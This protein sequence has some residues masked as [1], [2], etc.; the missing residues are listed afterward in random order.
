RDHVGWR[1]HRRDDQR[2]DNEVAALADELVRGDDADA[3]EQ[4]QDHGKLERDAECEDQLH[5]QREVVIHLGQ[6][7]DDRAALAAGLLHAEREPR[8]HRPKHAVHHQRAEQEEER[9]RDQVGPEGVALVSVQPWRDEHVELRRHHRKREEG[10]A[11]HRDLQLHHE[12]L[13]K[14]GVDELAIVE[15]CD[16]TVRKGEDIED[17]LGEEEADHERDHERDCC[18]DQA[19]AQLDQVL[20]QR[21][22]G[23]LDVL[24][25][26]AAR[27]PPA[28]GAAAAGSLVATAGSAAGA[29]AG[30]CA[31][32]VGPTGTGCGA[33]ASA[34]GAGAAAAA[35][36][37]A[38]AGGS[39]SAA[40]CGS[41]NGW[42]MPPPILPVASSM[43]FLM[44]AISASRMASR[45][46][47]WNSPA[48]RRIFPVHCPT[49]RSTA[50]KSFGLMKMS[51][52]SAISSSSPELKSNMVGSTPRGAPARGGRRPFVA[53][54][55]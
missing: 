51:T 41:L 13:E 15:A 12:V 27:S 17:R 29:G 3:A 4:R 20:D 25:G 42:V 39:P 9:R 16:P 2:D 1:E 53:C 43:S 23:G 18:L 30:V 8:H 10:G 21:R 33:I 11:E 7:L 35:G 6:Q 52:A 38:G 28:G 47:S 40:S 54:D 44:S 36:G 49:V 19:R 32:S 5:H 14:A 46:W 50:G 37:V 31:V 22:L 26:H 24:V 34:G 55:A 45:N 48:M